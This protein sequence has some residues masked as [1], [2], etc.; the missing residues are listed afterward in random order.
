MSFSIVIPSSTPSNLIGC[1][2]SILGREPGIRPSDIVVVDDG[3]RAEAEPFLPGLTWIAGE[4]PFIFARNANA[5][6]AASASDVV[7]MNDDAQLITNRGLTRMA[8]EMQAR[9]RVGI[10]S[11]GV[12]GIVGNPKQRAGMRP[13]FRLESRTLAFICVCIRRRVIGHVGLLDARY[14]GYGFE[15]ND[16]CVRVRQAGYQLAIWDGC[17]VDHSGHLPSTFRSR[18]DLDMMFQH[19]RRLYEEKWGQPA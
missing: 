7:L 4:K 18:S 13:T 1:V 2:R 19:N 5:G 12:R 8:R 11:A 15:D 16:Y 3:A 6:I 17:H 9:P 14:T 10:C